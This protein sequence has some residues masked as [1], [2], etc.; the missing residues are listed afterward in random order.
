MGEQAAKYGE[1]LISES[2]PAQR[3]NSA[4]Y[5]QRRARSPHRGRRYPLRTCQFLFVFFFLDQ[6]FQAFQHPGPAFY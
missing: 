6:F 5:I 4:Y 2:L 1:N 3:Q